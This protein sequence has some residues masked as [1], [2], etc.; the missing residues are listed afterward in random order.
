MFLPEVVTELVAFVEELFTKFFPSD[1]AE[2]PIK[3]E[4]LQ[5]SKCLFVEAN[6]AFGLKSVVHMH[7]ASDVV[8]VLDCFAIVDVEKSLILLFGPRDNGF[9]FQSFGSSCGCHCEDFCLFFVLSIKFS[10]LQ[11][12]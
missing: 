3:V 10:K 1:E 7:K 4:K 2:E 9:G 11:I 6:T 12:V 8:Q 5:M